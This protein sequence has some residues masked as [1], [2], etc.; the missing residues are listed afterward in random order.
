MNGLHEWTAYGATG[1]YW[2]HGIYEGNRNSWF[3][4][5]IH[6]EST[7]NSM[8]DQQSQAPAM[9]PTPLDEGMANG[10]PA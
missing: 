2:A 5:K 3:I 6:H 1:I 9:H 7:G 4:Y 8:S 10:A